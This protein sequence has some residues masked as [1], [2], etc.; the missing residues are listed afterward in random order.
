MA[1]YEPVVKNGA[2]GAIFY[3]A[4]LDQLTPGSFKANPTLAAGDFKLSID[5]GALANLTTLPTVTPAAGAQV[6]F[7]LTQAETNGDV[8]VIQCIDQTNPKEWADALLTVYT[9]AM[10]FDA[11]SARTPAALAG[12]RMDASLGAVQTTTNLGFTVPAIGRATVTAGATTTAIPTSLCTPAGA[13]ADQFKD[14]AILFDVNTATASLRGVAKGIT[15]SSNAA[16]PTFTV[17]P[18]LPAVP[19]VGDTFS[20]I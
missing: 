1:S 10:N 11:L 9:V 8:V 2:A 6:K 3:A 4:L 20:I 16:A 17:S 12:G 15:A 18:A 7:T 5:G 19:A 14:R 13:V